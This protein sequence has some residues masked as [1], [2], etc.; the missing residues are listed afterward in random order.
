MRERENERENEWGDYFELFLLRAFRYM[1]E[2]SCPV[3]THTHNHWLLGSHTAPPAIH[4]TRRVLVGRLQHTQPPA[5]HHP[6]GEWSAGVVT[7][8]ARLRALTVWTRE[9]RA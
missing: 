8:E 1:Y 9:R 4:Y 7:T 2:R 3:Y 5:A 6:A